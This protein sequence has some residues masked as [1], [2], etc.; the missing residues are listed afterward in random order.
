M[1]LRLITYNILQMNLLDKPK[2]AANYSASCEV[3]M[4]F[5]TTGW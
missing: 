3:T 4:P 5:F 1:A 2:M